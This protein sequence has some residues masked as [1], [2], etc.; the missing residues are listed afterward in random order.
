[1]TPGWPRTYQPRPSHNATQFLPANQVARDIVGQV[2]VPL[3]VVA[4]RR[5]QDVVV[6]LLAVDIQLVVAQ[7]VDVRPWPAAASP[8]I[9]MSCAARGREAA[10]LP[11]RQPDA[12]GRCTGPTTRKRARPPSTTTPAH[13][14]ARAGRPCPRREPS[15][16]NLLAGGQRLAR[17][18]DKGGLV[19]VNLPRVPE[20]S[21]VIPEGSPGCWPPGLGRRSA[22]AHG[23]QD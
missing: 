7:R 3:R 14:T 11:S 20:V 12:P 16:S 22:A 6:H 8:S 17:V 9:R 10:F 5:A 2:E 23:G 19:G 1:M 13:S 4:D 18:D 15:S 21:L